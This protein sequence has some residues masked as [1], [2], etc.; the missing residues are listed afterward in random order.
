MVE[1]EAQHQIKDL[2]IKLKVLSEGLIEERK[3]SQSYLARVKEYDGLLIQK[4]NEIQNLLKDKF[5]LQSKLDIEKSCQITPESN[6]KSVMNT[7]LKTKF[8]GQE[9]INQLNQENAQLKFELQ[10]QKQK[11]QEQIETY[12]QNKAKFQTL[13]TIQGQKLKELEQ[14]NAKLINDND[15]LKQKNYEFYKRISE[16]QTEKEIVELKVNKFKEQIESLKEKVN[17]LLLSLENKTNELY[18]KEDEVN[19]L[20]GQLALIATKM[21]QLKNESMN[22][23]LSAKTFKVQK[24]GQFFTNTEI[25]LV[26]FPN[27]KTNIYELLIS[28]EGK[29]D[30]VNMLDVDYFKKNEQYLNRVDICYMV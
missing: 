1:E 25:T 19:G 26:F 20:K 30:I 15:E 6:F 7:L 14:A 2:V 4:D 21:T 16:N 22:H 27:A 18:A 29:D 24:I 28:D 9:E 3:K 13:F 5:D 23:S 12:D 17:Q 11:V 8:T 10:R